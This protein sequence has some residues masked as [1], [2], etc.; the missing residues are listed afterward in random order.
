[1]RQMTILLS[2]TFAMFLL[3]GMFVSPVAC[4]TTSLPVP[5]LNVGDWWVMAF[6]RKNAFAEDTSYHE[7]PQRWRYE[8][9]GTTTIAEVLCY[10][11]R[12]A[13]ISDTRTHSRTFYVATH[14]LALVA[15]DRSDGRERPDAL[16]PKVIHP[17]ARSPHFTMFS[18]L[19]GGPP[20]LPLFGDVL[21]TQGSPLKEHHAPWS[22]DGVQATVLGG[23]PAVQL[24]TDNSEF[25]AWVAHTSAPTPERSV[26]IW[27]VWGHT[28]A[29]KVAIRQIWAPQI[30][31]YLYAEDGFL[32]PAASNAEYRTN[33][34]F[35][36]RF[37]SWM[38]DSVWHQAGLI[39]NVAP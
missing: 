27:I 23:Y 24:A 37:R 22:L 3:V 2:A 19:D 4:S 5:T 33:H 29:A 26:G 10:E 34:G 14:N 35:E 36:G 30:G 16:G 25:A 32:T 38:V 12:A 15:I 17:E 6:A 1:M 28:P 21:T 20:V 11:I 18:A 7:M 9:T 39:E 8:V 31:W 13:M